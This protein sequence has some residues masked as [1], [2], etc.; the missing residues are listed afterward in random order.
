MR[1]KHPTGEH[2]STD[3]RQEHVTV[4]QHGRMSVALTC[5]CGYS[6]LVVCAPATALLDAYECGERQLS[7]HWDESETDAC[8]PWLNL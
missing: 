4:T 5:G 7:K 3:V 2:V 1:E 8:R 6:V